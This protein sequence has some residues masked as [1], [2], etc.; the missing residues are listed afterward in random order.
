M[1]LIWSFYKGYYSHWYSTVILQIFFLHC[2]QLMSCG[3]FY[4]DLKRL[5]KWGTFWLLACH[6]VSFSHVSMWKTVWQILSLRT[7]PLSFI[8]WIMSP[9]HLTFSTA[10][11]LNVNLITSLFLFV[12]SSFFFNFKALIC[13]PNKFFSLVVIANLIYLFLKIFVFKCI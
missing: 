12:V 5:E 6:Q 4:F 10:E 8:M 7:R 9:C 11:E 3:I 2:Y 1:L 13:L